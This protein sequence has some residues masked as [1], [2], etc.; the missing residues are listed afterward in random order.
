M[1]LV[2]YDI[3]E[4]RRLKRVAKLLNRYGLR[5]QKSVY[6][7]DIDERRYAELRRKLEGLL[8]GEDGVLCYRMM[9]SM[10][11]EE[12]TGSGGG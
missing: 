4:P 7:C 10:R 11:K 5:V 9:Q 3:T 8:E 2:S 12:L 1:Y 6:E